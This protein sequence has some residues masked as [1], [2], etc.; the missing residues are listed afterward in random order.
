MW[1][2]QKTRWSEYCETVSCARVKTQPNFQY[3]PI[4]Q[5]N[6][7]DRGRKL[8]LISGTNDATQRSR[9]EIIH[10][11]VWQRPS[12]MSLPEI[13]S[14]HNIW[15]KM[16]TE[17]RLSA[18]TAHIMDINTQKD[19]IVAIQWQSGNDYSSKI[20]PEMQ[21]DHLSVIAIGCGLAHRCRKDLRHAE[22]KKNKAKLAETIVMETGGG[23]LGSAESGVQDGALGAKAF[24]AIGNTRFVFFWKLRMDTPAELP[25]TR[26][27][28]RVSPE[29]SSPALPCPW[30]APKCRNESPQQKDVAEQRLLSTAEVNLNLNV[31]YTL[32]QEVLRGMHRPVWR[33][34]S[35]THLWTVHDWWRLSAGV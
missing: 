27:G 2:C 30:F 28:I 25:N 17:Q 21:N 10:K 34:G 9:I 29:F 32:K 4:S 22:A 26:N 11:T 1:K 33:D 6:Q 18:S 20:W 16:V 23:S 3:K 19:G 15:H 14:Q 7:I 24:Y 8:D 5:T 35:A 12:R 13:M 31:I